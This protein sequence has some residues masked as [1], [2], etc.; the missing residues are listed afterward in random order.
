MTRQGLLKVSVPIAL[1]LLAAA[2]VAN[3]SDKQGKGS[4]A[5]LQLPIVGNE[6]SF[7]GKV[8]IQKFEARGG[9]VVAIGMVSGSVGARTVL[10]GPVALPVTLGG[11]S[12]R[13]AASNSV[14]TQQ[15]A[16]CQVLHVAIGAV[17]LDVLGVQV[18]TAP[19]DITLAGDSAGVLGNLVCTILETLNNVVGL[20]DLLNQ[21]LGVLT[22][23]VGGLVP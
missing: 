20:V 5:P 13:A 14:I 6:G 17:N 4:S 11:D 21:L 3:Q 18:T 22:G 8:S 19:I 12:Q 2:A 23:L 7:T 10:V 1:V 15:Q 9:A 16:T